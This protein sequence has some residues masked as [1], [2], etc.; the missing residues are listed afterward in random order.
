MEH[1]PN[2]YNYVHNRKEITT[3]LT[4]RQIHSEIILIVKLCFILTTDAA[5]CNSVGMHSII[6]AQP[7]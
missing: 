3:D 4:T 5:F 6:Q 7:H 2:N 1:I